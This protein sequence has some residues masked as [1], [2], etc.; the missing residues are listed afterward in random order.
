[1]KR[2]YHHYG[3]DPNM[4]MAAL[5]HDLGKLDTYEINP[6]TGKPTAYGHEFVAKD[7]IRKFKDWILSYEGTDIDEIE[8]IVSNHMKVKPRTWD[9]MRDVK[10]EP[11]QSH[12]S[13][14]K[15][16]G[17]TDKLDGGG[18]DIEKKSEIQEQ[19]S[20]IKYLYKNINK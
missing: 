2:A 10:K 19:I 12:P 7:Y 1:L 15:L 17:F 6:K 5:F 8:Y 9:T 13:F 16:K 18:Y 3:D 20:K 11:I 14:E 4:I